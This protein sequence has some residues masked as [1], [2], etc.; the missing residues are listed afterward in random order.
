MSGMDTLPI[1]LNELAKS[2][3]AVATEKGWWSGP[4]RSDATLSLLMT[5]EISEALEDFRANKDP[6]HIWYEGEKPCGIPIELADFIIRV[7]DYAG[8]KGLD[9]DPTERSSRLMPFSEDLLDS[10]ARASYAI[11]TFYAQCENPAD[12]TS[13]KEQSERY[14][15][16][17]CEHVFYGCNANGIELVAAI[18]IKEAFNRT[19]PIRHGGKKV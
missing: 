2:S 4:E 9:L 6:A 13:A 7:A 1:N 3:Y 11:S 10:W 19:R 18:R 15:R 12:R 14:L 16:E 8:H 17:A 5:S